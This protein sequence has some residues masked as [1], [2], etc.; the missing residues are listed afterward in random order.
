MLEDI[1]TKF[2]YSSMDNTP[3]LTG[4]YGELNPLFRQCLVEGFNKKYPSIAELN[5]NKLI[6]TYSSEHGYNNAQVIKIE[7]I[8]PAKYEREF[9][10]N[11]TTTTTVTILLD[12][13]F[14]ET[15]LL[16]LEAVTYCAP[17]GYSVKFQDAEQTI[18]TSPDWDGCLKVAD[19]M[20]PNWNSTYFK[21]ARIQT[22]LD[23]TDIN[24]PVGAYYPSSIQINQ[25]ASGVPSG[26]PIRIYLSRDNTASGAENKAPS[27]NSTRR[28]YLIGDSRGFYFF[29]VPSGN[30][31]N[32]YLH[33]SYF[34]TFDVFNEEN[35]YLTN[36]SLFCLATYNNSLA[37]TSTNLSTTNSFLGA[38]S[39]S[40]VSYNGYYL[41]PITYETWLTF[42]G[43]SLVGQS[44]SGGT[45]NNIADIDSFVRA[46][47]TL[48]TYVCILNNSKYEVLGQARGMRW[49]LTAYEALTNRTEYGYQRYTFVRK[50]NSQKTLLS[51][52]RSTSGYIL[53]DNICDW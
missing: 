7:G 51:M 53:F 45:Y 36:R 46:D 23:Y 35:P 4:E 33:Y 12:E 19:T 11:S 27:A 39:R 25:N 1:K 18:Y 34:G 50:F 26:S 15:P 9:R 16:S 20:H 44:L 2:Y 13:T 17:L 29:N 48:P 43:P 3:Q 22:A 41:S 32:A 42:I 24:T 30:T 8:S 38:Y 37:T 28:W 14:T 6:L 10:I 49:C 40:G 5:D 31:S 21:F 47:I 52:E